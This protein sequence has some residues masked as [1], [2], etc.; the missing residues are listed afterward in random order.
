[1]FGTQFAHVHG[2]LDSN[3]A[4]VGLEVDLFPY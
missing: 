4:I 2:L 1:M 3:G